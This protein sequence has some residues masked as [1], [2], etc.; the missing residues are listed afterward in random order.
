MFIYCF[1]KETRDILL[2]NGYVQLNPSSP[3]PFIFSNHN[4]E[5]LAS[6][7]M[8]KNRYVITNELIYLT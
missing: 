8:I 5:W 7:E 4:D 2:K 6:L 3:P 1:D